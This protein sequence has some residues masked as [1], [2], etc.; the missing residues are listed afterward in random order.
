MQEQDNRRVDDGVS[1]LIVDDAR[2]TCEMIR[3]TLLA[4]GYRDVRI[5]TSATEALALMAERTADIVLADWVMPDLDGLA[6]TRRIRQQ[7]EEHGHY[8]YVMLL[9]ASDDAASLAEAFDRGV[10]DFITKSPDHQELVAR[11]SAAARVAGLQNELIEA[12]RRLLELNRQLGRQARGGDGLI[13]DA[14]ATRI[15]VEA[16]IRH[17]EGRGGI[18]MLGLMRVR[19]YE[20]ERTAY[21][22]SLDDVLVG[23]ARRLRQT[24]RPLDHV[25]RLDDDTFAIVML[26]YGREAP[27]PNAFRR[28]HNALNLRAYKTR[29]GFLTMNVAMA[30]CTFSP[31]WR[32]RPTADELLAFTEPLLAESAGISQV[33]VRAWTG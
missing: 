30:V 28:T 7:D 1:I 32:Q 33:V 15:R 14:A 9:T 12:N 11:I 2:F 4:A 26:H 16:L 29:G 31:P 22:S 19:H 21:G 17:T 13:D 24:T 10:D 27:H 6:L 25:G 23:I 8:T 5:A 18:G 3:R 20:R